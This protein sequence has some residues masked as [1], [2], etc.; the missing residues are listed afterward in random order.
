MLICLASSIRPCQIWHCVRLIV[1]PAERFAIFHH[2]L[3]LVALLLYEDQ[4]QHYN[5]A[6]IN[7][8][9]GVTFKCAYYVITMFNEALVNTFYFGQM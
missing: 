7:A 4:V 2:L 5:I 6:V 3:S 9:H 1:Y 8:A